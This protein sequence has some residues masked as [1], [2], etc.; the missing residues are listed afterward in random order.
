MRALR[1]EMRRRT[2]VIR[3]LPR[4]IC[5]ENKVTPELASNKSLRLHPIVIEV[6]ECQVWFE[7]PTHGGEFEEIC[8]DLTKRG[9]ALGMVQ[10]LATQRPDAKS[11][12]TGISANAVL[13]MCL[14]VMGWRENDM[15][16]GTGAHGRGVQATM[17][18]FEDKGICYF[19]GEG[20][21]P[22]IVRSVYI[23][24]PAAE[25][26]A[27]RA[28]AARQ[29]AGT[30][31]G[32]AL[33]EEPDGPTGPSFD[34]LADILAVVSEPK[35]WSETVVTRLAGLRPKVYGPWGGMEPDARAAQLTAALKPHGV[36]TGQVWGTTD[37]GKG[38]N[39]RGITRD[40]IT[41]A[42]TQRDTKRG[43]SGAA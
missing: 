29:H 15:V 30:L 33:G 40:D 34:L 27:L 8:T 2:K 41:N 3:E 24:A 43:P 6:D 13:R 36:S 10:I 42:I 14:K 31:S 35:V 21:D 26:I 19:S 1:E 23:D 38:A 16:L 25:K 12:P 9:P 7:H 37:D 22:H 11:L 18:S 20:D 39:R 28:R 17:F 32:H 5:P 4:D